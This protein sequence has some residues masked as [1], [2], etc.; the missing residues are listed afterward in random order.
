M[1]EDI[2]RIRREAEQEAQRY[3]RDPKGL[4]ERA[5]Q[6]GMSDDNI[7]RRM[8]QNKSS[9]VVH[10]CAEKFAKHLGMSIA[11]FKRIAGPRSV[12]L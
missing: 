4:I 1:V 3:F 12:T 11:Q 8:T 2:Q 9:A 7:V 10:A 6:D 5:R